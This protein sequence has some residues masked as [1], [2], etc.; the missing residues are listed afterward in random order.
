MLRLFAL[1]VALCLPLAA[2]AQD[3]RDLTGTV[4]YR[5]R[6]ALPEGALLIV[7]VTDAAG[8]VVAEARLP[9]EGRQ[10]PIP[11]ALRLPADTEGS[12]RAGLSLGG[13]VIWL[14]DPVALTPETP[15]DLG[16]L[17]LARHQ[18]MGFASAFLCG[19]RRVM[20]GFAG[21]A[22]VMDTGRGDRLVLQSVPAA[23][24]ARYELPG[25]PGTSFWNRG[26][27][28]LISIGGTDLPACRLS[29]PMDDATPYRAGGN[30]PFWSVEVA[31][32]TLTLRRLGMDDLILPVAATGLSDAGDILVMA[33][34]ATLRRA[35]ALCRDSMTGMPHPETVTLALEG[36]TLGG[37]DP[38]SLLIG[39][40][41]VVEDI[42]GAGV[43]DAAR[44][45]L[46]F[47]AGGRVAGTGGCNRWFAGYTLTGE[48]L[49]F[50]EAGATMMACAP[51][52]MDQEQRF[53]AALAQVTRFDIDATGALRLI[54]GDAPVITARA[55]T[56]GSAP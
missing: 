34:A 23:S 16:E 50:G 6:M 26:E 56:D 19:D 37:G 7:E 51:A 10:V 4:T 54:A 15:A 29:F 44:V 25:D 53:F 38:A 3:S 41:W 5:D 55:A 48:G 13:E 9:T 47:A 42:G 14:G 36:E 12:L 39:P 17:V 35:P 22:L 1:I 28:A 33:G 2:P 32:G 30:E 40:A 46:G 11:F 21:E 24:G 52:L 20:V 8:A 27:G 45:T 43:I 49:T 31:G 18:P